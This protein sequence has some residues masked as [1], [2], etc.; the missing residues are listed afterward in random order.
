M[1]ETRMHKQ[2]RSKTRRRTVPGGV[3]A[4]AKNK[5]AD[6]AAARILR[7][8]PCA[9]ALLIFAPALKFDFIYDDHAQIAVNPQVQSWA[10]LPRLLT[11]HL[12]SQRGAEN[13]GYYYRPLFSLWLLILHTLGG[14]SPWFWHLG[15]VVLH[16]LATYF[17]FR[18]CLELLDSLAAASFSA[19]LFAVHPIHIESVCWV[20]ACDEILCTIFVLASLLLFR[21][22]LRIAPGETSTSWPSVVLWGGAL[23]SKETAV[24]VLPLFFFLAYKSEDKPVASGAQLRRAARLGAPFLTAALVYLAA[25]SVIL[26]RSGLEAG[27]QTWQ[28]VLY[29]S[30]SV[31]VFYIGKLL[32]P[33]RLS[34]FYLTPL[35]SSPT[36]RTWFAAALILG[37][38]AVLAW[39]GVKRSDATGGGLAAGL[40]AGLLVLPILPA[41]VGM[42]LFRAGDLVHD[43]YLYLPSVGLCLL[44]G[45]VAKRLW[46]GAKTTKIIAGA[47]GLCLLVCFAWLNLTQQGFYKND[48]L[49]F[50]R[51]IE[52]DHNNVLAI[53]YLGSWYFS[54]KQMGRALEEFALA[55]KLEPDDSSATFF[56]ATGLFVDNQYAAAEPYLEE[57]AHTPRLWP[58]Q[59][60]IVLLCLGKAE[61]RLGHWSHAEEVLGELRREDDSKPGLHEALGDVYQAEGK[62]PE[63]QAEYAREFQVSRDPGARQ[64]ALDLARVLRSRPANSPPIPRVPPN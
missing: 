29:T 37:G 64:K 14:L 39:L 45:M 51:A 63:A 7:W 20:S 36:A 52:V 21:R 61:I 24:A 32:W 58:G 53:D 49:F 16:A 25:R 62:I 5:P 59:R 55:H 43:R 56:L 54:E 17:V 9:L 35:L 12:W 46:R 3:T 13:V 42:R 8:G 38:C 23:L 19:F 31:F 18:L 47:M 40:A 26:H 30:P 2:A 33:V 60:P 6:S 44:T 41:L 34:G 4:S 22:R 10:F 48:E 1:R 57:L 28:Q 11:T 15:S 27:Q 50:R